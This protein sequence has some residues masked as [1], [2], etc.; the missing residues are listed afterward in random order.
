M[1]ASRCLRQQ[2][3]VAHN[4]PFELAF[5]R[6]HTKPIAGVAGH[7]VECTAQ[8]AGLVL[9]VGHAGE[10][11][12]LASV[13]S[14]RLKL[15]PPKELQTSDWSAPRL[16]PGQL[17]YA[18]SDAVLAWKL[19]PNL[20]AEII[21]RRCTTAYELQ[22][23]AIPAVAD[24][25]LR[26]LGFDPVEHTRQV[27]AWSRNL[28]DARHQYVEMTGKAPPTKPAEVRNWVAAVA[29]ERLPTWPRSEK[30]GELSIERKHLKRLAL[31]EVA[32]VKPVLS[33]LAMEKLISTFGP[34]LADMVSPATGRIH[35]RYNI[36]AAKSGRFTSSN[37]NLQQLPAARAPEFR[38][39][40][41][42][43]PGNVLISCDWSQV[44]MRAAAWLSKD[45]VL[46][47]VYE[48]GRDLH[49]ETAAAIARVPYAAVT[50]AQRQAAKPV[51]FGAI[52]GIGPV[53]LAEDAFDNYEIELT[54]QE[55]QQ[56]L[57][58]FF[59]TYGG[60]NDWRWDH[61]RRVKAVNRVV[62]PG[63]GRTVEG[64]W[65]PEGRIRFPQACNIPI[66]GMCADAMLRA[67]ALLF[68]RLRGAMVACLHDEILIEVAEDDADR[69]GVVLEEVMTEAFALTFPGAPIAGVAEVGVGR[70]WMEAKSG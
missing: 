8:A 70:N 39:C 14:A 32:T 17:A 25:E 18:A 34:K 56:A 3:L 68:R 15:D 49:R 54:E 40:I 35:C 10:R 5:L 45:R 6:H 52:Y 22:R 24:M 7:P 26:G 38:R 57:D 44:E 23:G 41:V 37:P 36:G 29:G 63:S 42:A 21:S 50:A 4:A 43:A 19:W 31:A 48:E 2:R 53:T 20:R 11:R 59:Q 12:S 30:T 66:Q 51:N 69:A 67:I 58:R 33:M 62:V 65:E 55:A 28:A 60:Y 61:W 46:T 1:L 9:G 27:E 64:V 47:R 16:S 13:A